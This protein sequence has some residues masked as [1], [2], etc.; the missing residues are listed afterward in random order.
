MG[1][2][3]GQPYFEVPAKRPFDQVPVIF[4]WH[5]YMAN[6]WYPGTEYGIGQRVRP[7][8]ALATGFEYEVT[9]TE[10]SGYTGNRRPIFPAQ[11]NTTVRSGA[12]TFTARALS[13]ASLRGVISDFTFVVPSPLSG[14]NPTLLN[15]FYTIIDISGGIHGGS[16]PIKSRIVLDTLNGEIKEAVA[17]LRVL[18]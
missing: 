11:L 6:L 13:T 4:D 15:T 10:G 3:H 2:Q 7:I 1:E 16:Y 14:V 17:L 5:D 18:D 9:S 12:V 8:R